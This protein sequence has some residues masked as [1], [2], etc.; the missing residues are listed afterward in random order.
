MGVGQALVKECEKLCIEWG[1]DVLSLHVD[2]S[3]KEAIN[4]Y[5]G[6]DFFEAPREMSW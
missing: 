2:E 1:H 4:F 3:N 6:L 5:R